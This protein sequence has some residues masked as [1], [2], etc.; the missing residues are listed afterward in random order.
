[1]PNLLNLPSALSMGDRRTM[2]VEDPATT[3]VWDFALDTNGGGFFLLAPPALGVDAEAGIAVEENKS[4]DEVTVAPSDTLRYATTE[5]VPVQIG[6][7]YVIR[8][9]RRRSSFGQLCNFYGKVEPLIL[10]EAG[11]SMTFRYDLSPSCNDLNLVP[12]N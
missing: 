5:P 3:G 2:R 6:N 7:I 1:M 9:N 12:P 10:D 8:T 4:Y 11:G